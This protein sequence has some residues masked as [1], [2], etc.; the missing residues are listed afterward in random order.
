LPR[1]RPPGRRRPALHRRVLQLPGVLAHALRA[2]DRALP[3]PAARRERRTDRE[4]SPWQRGAGPA[5]GPSDAA[6]AAAR[7]RLRDG[8]GRQV[9]PRLPAA[10]RTAEERL[11][12]VLRPDERWPRLFH[13]PR[14]GRTA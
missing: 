10:L 9:A 6:L 2:D 7:R 3:V 5:A 14:L 12:G 1:A 8:P 13:P 11:P 4:P